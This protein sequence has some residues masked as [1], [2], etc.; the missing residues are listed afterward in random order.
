V[1]KN[2]EILKHNV[3][4]APEE[5]LG[6]RN[7]NTAKTTNWTQWFCEKVKYLAEEK[8]RHT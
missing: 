5:A 8:E 7:V 1:Y 2:C 6:T 4:Q 3:H